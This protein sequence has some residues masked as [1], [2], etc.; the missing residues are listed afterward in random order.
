MFCCL[1]YLIDWV[2]YVDNIII[3]PRSIMSWHTR[4]LLFRFNPLVQCHRPRILRFFFYCLSVFQLV[5][6][7]SEEEKCAAHVSNLCAY[8]LIGRLFSSDVARSCF[9]TPFASCLG[10]CKNHKHGTSRRCIYISS[11]DIHFEP[12]R[13]E[14]FIRYVE[15]SLTIQPYSLHPYRFF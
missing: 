3:L 4:M 5:T 10:P 9:M 14:H 8:L 2:S 6:N 12:T 15:P 1:C 13:N 7:K 11:V